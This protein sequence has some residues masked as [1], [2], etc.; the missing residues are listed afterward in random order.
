MSHIHHLKKQL[1][2]KYPKISLEVKR[3][4]GH[5]VGMVLEE[6]RAKK[7]LTQKQLAS[8]LGTKQSAIAR[9]ESGAQIPSLPYLCKIAEVFGTY[10]IPPKFYKINE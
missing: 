2:K 9:L 3:D 7:G 4:I 8:L 10:L 5:Q 6:L 1:E